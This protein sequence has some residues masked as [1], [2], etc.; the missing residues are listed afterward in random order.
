MYKP[1]ALCIYTKNH[2]S[3]YGQN[4]YF[5]LWGP[6]GQLAVD[7]KVNRCWPKFQ[8]LKSDVSALCSYFYSSQN[9]FPGSEIVDF[10]KKV[11]KTSK[12]TP[13]PPL[14]SVMRDIYMINLSNTNK[15]RGFWTLE[16]DNF[17]S[18]W[19]MIKTYIW[20]SP[21]GGGGMGTETKWPKNPVSVTFHELWGSV[22][23]LRP[24]QASFRVN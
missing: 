7:Q 15:W 21:A 23:P 5:H 20:L 2:F 1:L 24:N 19:D 16:V 14:V 3:I 8:I 4:P 9:L 6:K 12:S 18:T 17:W 11:R 22:R 13:D 10:L